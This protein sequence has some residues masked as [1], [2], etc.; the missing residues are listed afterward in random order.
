M[1]LAPCHPY[2]NKKIKRLVRDGK[3]LKRGR[4]WEPLVCDC[5]FEIG[6]DLFPPIPNKSASH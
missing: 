5:G 4:D 3:V 1:E 6:W 2:V